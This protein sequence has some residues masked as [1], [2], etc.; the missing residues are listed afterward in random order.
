MNNIQKTS[1]RGFTLIELLV[2][3]LIIGIISAIALPQYEKAIT[4]TRLS[5]AVQMIKSLSTGVEEYIL[6]HGT[7][8]SKITDT[9][10]FPTL[11]CGT[12]ACC[13]DKHFRYCMQSAGLPRLQAWSNNYQYGIIWN[14][15]VQPQAA[16]SKL[17]CFAVKDSEADKKDYCALIGAEDKIQSPT[18]ETFWWY[19]L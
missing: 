11:T 9:N 5:T 3:V 14:S 1:P 7:T 13:S 19:P 10:I 17:Y 15:S 18:S 12:D 2:V 8:P 16:T 4:K 6:V